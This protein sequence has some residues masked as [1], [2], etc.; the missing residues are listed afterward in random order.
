[1]SQQ[2]ADDER[3]HVFDNPRNVKRL[4]RALY[5]CCAVLFGLDFF[6]HR[7][8]VHPWE[9]APAFY[10]VYGFVACVILVLVAKEMRKLL[11]RPDDFY[12]KEEERN[13]V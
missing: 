1:M 7:H 10:A 12:T 9:N 5:A 11:M 2:H 13:D 8:V 3:R 6:L 4:L